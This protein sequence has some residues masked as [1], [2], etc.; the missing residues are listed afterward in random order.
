MNHKTPLRDRGWALSNYLPRR[1][2]FGSCYKDCPYDY[3]MLK[4]SSRTCKLDGKEYNLP[5]IQQFGGVCAMQADYAA[6]IGKSLGVP[7]AYVTGASRSGD[8]H[9]WVMWV[10]L[11]GIN[12]RSIQFSL[13]SYGRYRGDNFYVGHLH[14]PQTGQKIT[15]RILELRLHQVGTDALKK[16]HAD[17]MMTLYPEFIA[18][19]RM[20]FDQKSDFLSQTLALNPWNEQA[21]AAVTKISDGEELDRLRDKQMNTILSQLFQTFARFPDFT[22]TVFEDLIQFDDDMGNQ[23]KAWYRL[24]DVYSASK[25]PDL[26]FNALIRLSEILVENERS[27]EAIQAL[28]TAVQRY[29]DEGNYVP[30]M[31]DR[32]EQLASK[33]DG[34]DAAIV[35]F[36]SVFLPKIPQ[37]RGNSPSEYCIAMYQRGISLFQSAGQ[38]Q[39]AQQYSAALT[40]LQASG[41]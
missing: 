34:G 16:R 40:T 25:R 17:R 2:M 13:E 3:E 41:Q 15:D 11:K 19:M 12:A 5:N 36:Y 20:D 1:A 24:L 29:P 8:L 38:T 37:K 14:D 7:A 4:T 22:L 32:L 30:K 31:L 27:D 21:W 28:A 33:I 6:R 35:Q 23:I 10:E 18:E 26:A 9:A 39:L